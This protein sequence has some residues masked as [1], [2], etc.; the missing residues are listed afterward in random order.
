MLLLAGHLLHVLTNLFAL[1]YHAQTGVQLTA[2]SVQSQHVLD[3][4]AYLAPLQTVFACF[5]MP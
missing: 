1:R 3:A 5:T 2:S 4:L